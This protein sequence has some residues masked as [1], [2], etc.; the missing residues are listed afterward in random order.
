[1]HSPLSHRDAQGDQTQFPRGA[2]PTPHSAL[3]SC[4]LTSMCCLPH[5]VPFSSMRPS[6]CSAHW[7]PCPGNHPRGPSAPE[8]IPAHKPFKAPRPSLPHLPNEAALCVRSHSR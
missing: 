7:Q 8:S 3:P 4:L 2:S 6:L 1:M 5:S